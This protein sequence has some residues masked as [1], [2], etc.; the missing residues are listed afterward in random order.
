MGAKPY[1]I[2][3]QTHV[4]YVATTR[5]NSTTWNE[6]KSYRAKYNFGGCLYGTPKQ[7]AQTIP[8]D[9]I[10]FILEM[11]N[12]PSVGQKKGNGKIM[13]IGVIR[14]R[15]NYSKYRSIYKDHNYNRY[16][17]IGKYRKDRTT[18]T[19]E[20][21]DYL[22]TLEKMVFHGYDHL[23]RGQGITCIP[24]KKIIGKQR[25]LLKYLGRL[26]MPVK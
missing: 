20:Q 19:P 1:M 26:F 12:M 16:T 10:L 6:N 3:T 11:L 21:I 17:Y 4:Y 25:K 15:P 5:F 2:T 18:M 23:K 22:Y 14:N 7:I 13:G 24:K 8:T 9:A